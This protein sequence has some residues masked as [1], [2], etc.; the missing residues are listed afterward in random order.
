[1]CSVV[2]ASVNLRCV[3]VYVCVRQLTSVVC[4]GVCEVAHVCM[5]MP[6]FVCVWLVFG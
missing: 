6:V 3:D 5:L 4:D 2:C 1:M